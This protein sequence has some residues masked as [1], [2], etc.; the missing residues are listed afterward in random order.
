MAMTC[1]T[2]SAFG[3]ANA[4]AEENAAHIEIAPAQEAYG[5]E[6]AGALADEVVAEADFDLAEESAAELT[7]EGELTDTEA[8][9]ELED[10]DLGELTGEVDADAALK[11]II[12]EAMDAN[13]NKGI[14]AALD[15]AFESVAF[16]GGDVL[17]PETG[18]LAVGEVV[19]VAAEAATARF[20]G[21]STDQ[22][23][24]A[25]SMAAVRA[26]NSG[27][28]D[29]LGNDPVLNSMSM[30]E[31]ELEQ[32]LEHMK[33]GSKNAIMYTID[34][35]AKVSSPAFKNMILPLIKAMVGDMFDGLFPQ[36]SEDKV[37]NKLN[38]IEQR[39]NEV[40][41][42]IKLHTDNVVVLAAIGDKYGT[43]RDRAQTLAARV[44][45]I[46]FNP[47]LTDEQKVEELAKLYKDGVVY[48]LET[49]LNG[50]TNAFNGDTEFSLEQKSVFDMAYSTAVE[51]SM[52]SQEAIE[53][54][55]PYL[56]PTWPAMPR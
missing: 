50:A 17:D 35:L 14:G 26:S 32:T 30:S 52:F 46:R 11:Q 31:Q 53:A 13:Q 12:D 38:Q 18:K 24:G 2:V 15:A 43:V 54:A 10:A 9:E 8:V 49:A 28:L 47:Y 20:A 25:V 48:D 55:T 37:M 56:I 21:L 41:D 39:I 36:S 34:Q 40:E 44:D 6:F 23:F 51:K 3:L 45:N 29:A 7:E 22:V 33:S 42:S 5:A 1:N 19:R 16:A 27:L 4:L